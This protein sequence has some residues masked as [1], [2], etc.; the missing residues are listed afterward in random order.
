MNITVQ[1]TRIKSYVTEMAR[2]IYLLKYDASVNSSSDHHSVKL[3]WALFF[4]SHNQA[5]ATI[6][7]TCLF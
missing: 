4:F 3:Q 1:L 5:G 7:A 2:D 6:S